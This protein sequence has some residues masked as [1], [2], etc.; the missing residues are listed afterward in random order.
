MGAYGL[1]G[2]RL[3]PALELVGHQVFR[4]GRWPD[5][6]WPADPTDLVSVEK[7]IS[8]TNPDVIINLNA[9]T[10][11]DT[12]EDNPAE[13]YRANVKPVEVFAA[14]LKEMSVYLVHVS[15]DQVY[16]GGGPHREANAFPCNVYGFSKY[17]SELA[18]QT[19][20]AAILRTNFVGRS[21]VPGRLGFTDWLYQAFSEHKKITLFEDVW[22]SPLHIDQLAS[23]LEWVGEK[24]PT[25]I[26][27]LGARDGIS[28][29]GFALKFA[30]RLGLDTSAAGFGKLAEE[31]FNALRPLDMQLNVGEFEH[32]RGA[33]L[34]DI[35]LVIS[36]TVADYS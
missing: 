16:S 23:A 20:R 12:C 2:S 26:F 33:K 30:N 22:F 9:L 29:A 36:A 28:K 18:C 32:L 15:T 13:A 4:Q 6:D 24:Q 3:C 27:N 17:A 14:L 19:M 10:N 25:G 1:L 8:K 5:A 21:V 34:P 7:L 11:V 35:E 31:Q